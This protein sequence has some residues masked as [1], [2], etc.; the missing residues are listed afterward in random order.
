MFQKKKGKKKRKLI[1]GVSA[2]LLLC[3]L[4]PLLALTYLL[5]FLVTGR[6][7]AQIEKTIV[8]SADK[9]IEIC[10]MQMTDVVTAS[11]NASYMSTIRSSYLNYL[12]NGSEEEL[13]NSVTQFLT[14]Q[15]KYNQNL[16]S[17]MLIFLDN[18]SEIYYTYGSGNA[19]N[20]LGIREFQQE[21]QE[22]IMM[23]AAESSTGVQ[24][25]CIDGHIF[26]IRNMV[27]SSYR[28]YA[29]IIMELN[30][31]S[32]F[33]SLNSVW[34]SIGF[35]VYVNDEELIT[36]GEYGNSD[37]AGFPQSFKQTNHNSIYVPKGREA[38]VYKVV[39]EADNWIA[40]R[41]KLDSQA[42]LDELEITKIMVIMLL[43]FMI[44]VILII[45]AF[46]YLK[47]NRR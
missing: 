2:I 43:L 12:S 5:L 39:K 47:V 16:R 32:I 4:I 42:I 3:W 26:M 14:Q 29:V 30:A 33:E 13:Y 18:M 45:F 36:A 17:T 44:P 10:Q 1:Y 46:L 23:I 28:P 8:T 9:A 20:Y 25:V 37:M 6:M 24:L 35:R 15:Y 40:F 19:V 11:R 27:D 31:E 38:C 41:I 34:G 21:Y 7:N 22:K